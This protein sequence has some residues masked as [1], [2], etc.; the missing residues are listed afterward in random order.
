MSN[1]RMVV[2]ISVDRRALGSAAA[3]AVAESIRESIATKGPV[4][5]VFGSA[6]SQDETLAALGDAPGIDWRLVTAFHLDEYVG[7]AAD[8]PYS[9]RRYLM[10][11]LFAQAKPG[12]F[13]GIRG[14][15]RDSQ[16]EA[17]RYAV[18]L[19]ET[20]PD[21]ALLGIGENGHLA[22]NDPPCDF[23]DPEPVKVVRLAETCRRQQVHD[24][25]FA[26]I[27]QV[28]EYAITLTIPTIMRIPR[29]YL[30]A[31]TVS[32]AAAIRDTL[33]GPITPQCPASVLRTHPH[34]L[35]FLNTDSASLL[36]RD[37]KSAKTLT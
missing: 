28:P 23:D 31:P 26:A 35:M 25:V 32:K 10:E 21:I 18:L 7:A 6:P 30:M 3:A 33:E 17:R 16:A 4:T 36:T 2:T 14:E 13:H 22:F 1:D 20:P 9:F 27:E 29:L 11:H 24:G 34:V 37:L 5:V 19:R 12:A 8:A 15:A